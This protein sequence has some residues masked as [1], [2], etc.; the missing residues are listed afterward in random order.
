VPQPPIEV[1]FNPYHDP[2]NGQFTFGPDGTHMG[3]GGA[4]A[5]GDLPAPRTVRK[6]AKPLPGLKTYAVKAGDSL[7]KIAGFQN[8]ISATDIANFNGIR[9]G[10]TLKIGQTLA[11]PTK[12]QLNAFY[13][14]NSELIGSAVSKGGYNFFLD[15]EG[16]TRAVIGFIKLDPDQIRS[17]TNQAK[18]GGADRLPTDEGGHYIARR[19]GGPTDAFNHFAQDKAFNR[20]DYQTLEN[21]WARA[22]QSGQRVWVSI[23]PRYSG[24]SIRPSSLTVIYK[25][26]NSQF[27]KFFPNGGGK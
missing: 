23:T 26:G 4:G 15:A 22:K 9:L 10:A 19:F 7:T 16:R 24:N 5:S 11:L 3:F 13:T 2:D 27:S 25:I 8:D 1:K 14:G 12:A 18:A 6:V 21:T 17:R 20:G